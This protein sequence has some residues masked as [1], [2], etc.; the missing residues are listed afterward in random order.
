MGLSFEFTVSEAFKR[1]LAKLQGRAV[2]EVVAEAL[3]RSL[4]QGVEFIKE[5]IPGKY[6]RTKASIRITNVPT[7]G[8]LRGSIVSS[9][10]SAKRLEYGTGIYDEEVGASRQPIDIRPVNKKVLHFIGSDGKDVFTKHVHYDG[11]HPLAMFRKNR[12][13]IRYWVNRNISAALREYLRST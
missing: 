12:A 13:R 11:L 3:S 7:A 2:R 8:N 6:E 10:P 9:D 5:D 1:K 4:E